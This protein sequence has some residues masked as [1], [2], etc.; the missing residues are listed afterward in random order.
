MA[1][2]T[3]RQQTE[4]G[5]AV[6]VQPGEAA[7]FWQPVPANGYTE[8]RLARENTGGNSLAMGLQVIAP[9]SFIREHWHDKNEEVLVF[10]EGT[11]KL[12]VNDDVHPIAPGTTAYL[13]RWNRHRIVNDTDRDLKMLWFLIPGGLEDFFQRI[14]RP[15]RPGEPAPAPFPR[16]ENVAEIERDTVFAP[17]PA[18]RD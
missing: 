14:G 3:A 17:L 8:V 6:V 7:S 13:G 4:R 10:I 16:P 18:K 15:R 11:G 9:H 1:D 2:G 5:R 12:E